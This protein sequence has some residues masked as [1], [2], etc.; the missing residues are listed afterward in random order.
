VFT[1]SFTGVGIVSCGL[2]NQL[3]FG[4]E[5]FVVPF[6]GKRLERK[7][8]EREAETMT[9][10]YCLKYL[11]FLSKQDLQKHGCLKRKKGPY[12]R[13]RMLIII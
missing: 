4:F 2:T 12:K 1:I 5:V 3:V 6:V 9:R 7:Q 13:C 11:R 8:G 10:Y